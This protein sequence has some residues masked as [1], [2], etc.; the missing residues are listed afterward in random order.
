[1]ILAPDHVRNSLVDIINN[2]RK[3]EDRLVER[4]RDDEITKI[5]RINRDRAAHD[6]LE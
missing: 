6:I 1:M 5:A 4:A 3:V 2:N